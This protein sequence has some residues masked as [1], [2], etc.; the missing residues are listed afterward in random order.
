M[1]GGGFNINPDELHHGAAQL[2][3]FSDS[4][5]K[6]LGKLKTT[7][8]NLSA[9]AS[10]DKSGVGQVVVKAATKS[11]EVMGNVAGEGARVVKGAEQRLH[12]GATAHSTNEETRTKAFQDLKPGES[13]KKTTPSSSG[14]GGP[15]KG[16]GPGG[17]GP[18]KGPG[19]GGGGPGKGPGKGGGG[20]KP[21]KKPKAS[22][23]PPEP[24]L[25]PGKKPPTANDTPS[26]VFNNQPKLPKPEKYKDDLPKVDSAG[27]VPPKPARGAQV[28]QI[29]EKR[30]K[31]GGDGLI[32]TVDG[33]PVKQY[34]G[35]LSSGRAQA[36]SA[37]GPDEKPLESRCS[38][39][40]IDLK[41]GL[42]T[43]GVNGNGGDVIPPKNLH[44]LLQQNYQDLRAW[45]HPVQGTTQTLDGKAHYSTPAGHAEVK[46]TNELLW[47]REAQLKPGETLPPSTLGE[48]RFDPRW[49]AQTGADGAIGGAAPACAN[50]NSLLDG[51]PS[52]TGRCTYTPRD[53]RYAN[54]SVA[55]YEDQ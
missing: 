3:T 18:G 52:Y 53:D 20:G 5:T 33:K 41:T 32:K 51:V 55:P 4:I 31:R 38:A 9:H 22:N 28:E 8:Q 2:G 44:P 15:S 23:E 46:A 26:K 12:A 47:A 45:Q 16:G 39:V 6:T 49:T 29:D 36:L 17:S 21:P 54:P 34:V 10:S 19:K 14:G 42:V 11:E 27:A 24:A 37:N 43:T 50:C 40:A 35:E 1:S 7:H 13:G 30:V 25:T 48:L